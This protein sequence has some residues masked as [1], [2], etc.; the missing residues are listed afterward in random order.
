MMKTS[1]KSKRLT[2]ILEKLKDENNKLLGQCPSYSWLLNVFNKI[3]T[4]EDF[5]HDADKI[6]NFL[7]DTY[8]GDKAIND[9]VGRFVLPYSSL[10]RKRR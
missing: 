1:G 7:A 3:Q 5:E 4:I 6:L 10:K 8:E 2:E 9:M